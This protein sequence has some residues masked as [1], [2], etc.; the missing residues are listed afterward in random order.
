MIG[1]IFKD[2]VKIVLELLPRHGYFYKVH[3]PKCKYNTCRA[4]NIC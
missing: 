1:V 2:F 3:V 4:H